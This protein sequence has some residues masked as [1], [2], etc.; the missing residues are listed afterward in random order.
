MFIPGTTPKT[1]QEATLEGVKELEH[2][3]D[4]LIIKKIFDRR[5]EQQSSAVRSILENHT[6]QKRN[7]QAQ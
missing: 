7:T 3:L 4:G 1:I 5:E 2:K 6:E